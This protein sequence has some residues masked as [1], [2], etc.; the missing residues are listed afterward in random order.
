MVEILSF[1]L[2]AF[3][4]TSNELGVVLRITIIFHFLTEMEEGEADMTRI[5][6]EVM[7]E[8]EKL[9]AD[10][11]SYV[12]EQEADSNKELLTENYVKLKVAKYLSNNTKMYFSG[13]DAA[14]GSV[15]GQVFG[16]LNN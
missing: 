5:R 16:N 9:K 13:E 10:V 3:S 4:T 2:K 1:P 12:A 14:L 8:T 6:N 11:S 7:E 15:L